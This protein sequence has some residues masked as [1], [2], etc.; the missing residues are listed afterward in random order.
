M[1][2]WTTTGVFENIEDRNNQMWNMNNIGGIDSMWLKNFQ[3]YMAYFE[4]TLPQNVNSA[5]YSSGGTLKMF[6][7]NIVMIDFADEQKCNYIYG[8]NTIAATKLVKATE[9]LYEQMF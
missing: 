8:L 9:M 1:M 4:N 6:M 5:S 3:Q 2:Y 7:P